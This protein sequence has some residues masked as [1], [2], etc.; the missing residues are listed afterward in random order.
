MRKT[1]ELT[2]TDI[3]QVTKYQKRNGLKNFSDAMR[4][5]I[6][7]MDNKSK[8]VSDENFVLLG[9]AL[10]KIDEKIDIVVKHLAPKSAGE[11]K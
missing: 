4:N 10:V 7:N 6:R 1:I 5:I 9:D 11:V 2:K 8:D 3:E